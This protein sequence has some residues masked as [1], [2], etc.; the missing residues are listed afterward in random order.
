ML[1]E[2]LK[3]IIHATFLEVYFSW[4]P[5]SRSY[6]WQILLPSQGR[7]ELAF[8]IHLMNKSQA[9][10]RHQKATRRNPG[11]EENLHSPKV[12]RS[13]VI[14]GVPCGFVPVLAPGDTYKVFLGCWCLKC[15]CTHR[16]FCWQGLFIVGINPGLP[17]GCLDLSFKDCICA[18]QL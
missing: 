15:S 5:Q 9:V 8:L 7:P 4:D 18:V 16:F 13:G 17:F 2:W 1:K 6:S 11:S 10:V 12:W 3:P 14:I